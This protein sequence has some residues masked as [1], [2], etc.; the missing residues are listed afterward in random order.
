VQ[1]WLTATPIVYMV[2]NCT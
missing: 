2:R 1:G